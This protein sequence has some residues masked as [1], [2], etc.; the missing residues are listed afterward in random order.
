MDK[1]PWHATKTSRFILDNEC[2]PII[3]DIVKDAW[4]WILYK[5][6]CLSKCLCNLQKSNS[7]KQHK[8]FKT[9]LKCL[10]DSDLASF[11]VIQR[12]SRL[13]N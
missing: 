4:N 13:M 10:T 8:L 11:Y 1:A 3:K 9:V 5:T 7:K 12:R 6:C 2:L